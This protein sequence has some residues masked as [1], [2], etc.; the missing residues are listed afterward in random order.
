MAWPTKGLGKSYNSHT[1]FA[2]MID[3]YLK[4]VINSCIYNRLCHFCK[5]AKK[6]GRDPKRYDCVK[7]YEGSAK[8]MELAE[9]LKIVNLSI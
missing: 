3:G 1:G 4:L 5:L 9:I 6:K 8:S 2:N 7:N